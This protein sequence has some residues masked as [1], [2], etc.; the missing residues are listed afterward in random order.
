MIDW[1]NKKQVRAYHNAYNKTHRQIANKNH[2]KWVQN[3]TLLGLCICCNS[4]AYKGRLC[5]VHYKMYKKNQQKYY[6]KNRTILM[7]KIKTRRQQR[8]EHGLCAYCNKK[9]HTSG[10]CRNHYEI[11][12]VS[13]RNRNRKKTILGLCRICNEHRYKSDMCKYHYE[14]RFVNPDKKE[15]CKILYKAHQERI[16]DGESIMNDVKFIKKIMGY[17][18]PRIEKETA[19]NTIGASNT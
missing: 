3:H 9:I 15:A 10:M 4:K 18:C 16:N 12:K 13:M 5:E 8:K 7:S 17:T 1:N 2:N 6:K 19:S 14:K 11:F